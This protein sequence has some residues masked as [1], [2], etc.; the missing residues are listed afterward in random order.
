MDFLPGSVGYDGIGWQP[1]AAEAA[2]IYWLDAFTANID[3]TWRNPNVLIWHR[4]LWAI[5]HGAAL[6]FQHAWP[7]A[8][9]WAGRRYD[10]S[11]HVLGPVV[12]TLDAAQ[13]DELDEKL[14][15]QLTAELLTEVLGLVPDAWLLEMNAA[16]GDPRDAAGWRARYVEYLLA[17]LEHRPEWRAEMNQ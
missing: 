4:Q 16:S 17:R 14:A 6:I 8:Q 9:T 12:A 5:D 1:P 15:A 11:E 10:L 13:L 7:P 2:A 3:R